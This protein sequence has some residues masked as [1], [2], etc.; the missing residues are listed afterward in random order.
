[1]VHD[2]TGVHPAIYDAVY[3]SWCA[4]LLTSRLTTDRP[5]QD[6]HLCTVSCTVSTISCLVHNSIS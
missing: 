2:G 5:T 3:K 4:G 1:V 6:V